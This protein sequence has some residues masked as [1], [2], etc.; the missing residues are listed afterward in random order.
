M[1]EP[2]TYLVEKLDELEATA[3]AAAEERPP[4]WRFVKAGSYSGV[5]ASAT[6]DLW[7]CE[8]SDSLCM[9]ETVAA[10]VALNDP[11][12]A[13]RHIAATRRLLELHKPKMFD[14]STGYD[15]PGRRQMCGHCY[16]ADDQYF[17]VSGAWPCPTIELLAQGYGWTPPATCTLYR[18]V[19]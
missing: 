17:N 1:T 7:D 5:V 4:P 18:A 12:T 14:F 15:E 3:K 8:G 16:T 10:H 9:D 11:A 19:T 2:A 13:L 6:G